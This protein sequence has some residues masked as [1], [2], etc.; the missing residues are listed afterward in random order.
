VFS[1]PPELILPIFPLP[2]YR[3]WDDASGDDVETVLRTAA[4]G[5]GT[6]ALDRSGHGGA[7]SGMNR[8]GHGR[9]LGFRASSSKDLSGGIKGKGPGAGGR[10]SQWASVLTPRVLADDASNR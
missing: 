2:R 1:T 4:D 9:S 8:S 5:T 3:C 6:D 7:L 10:R